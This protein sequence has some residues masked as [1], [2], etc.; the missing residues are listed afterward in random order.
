MRLKKITL[1][2]FK[3][4][5][6]KITL[7]FHPG[8]TAIVGPNGCGKS[9]IAD[10]FRWVLGEQSAK[11]LRGH[12]MQDVIFAGTSQRRPVNLSEVT[13]TLTDIDGKLPVEFDEVAISRRLHRSGESEYLL[14]GSEVRLKDLQAL[15][16]DSGIGKEAFSIFEQGK[17]DQV[18]HY[19]PLERRSIFEEAAGIVRFL[20]RK[21]EALRKLEQTELNL[22]RLVDILN[23]VTQRVAV[24]EE[25]AAKARQF[26]EKKTLFEGLE[27]QLL[28][29]KW[30]LGKQKEQQ[31]RKND[32]EST[33]QVQELMEHIGLLR[34]SLHQ[35]RIATHEREQAWK[36]RSA[37]MYAKRNERDLFLRDKSHLSQKREELQIN[38]SS[39]EQELHTLSRQSAENVNE[40][41]NLQDEYEK[42]NTLLNDLKT[43]LDQLRN[44][45]Q[46]KTALLDESRRQY[47]SSQ[48]KR[49]TATQTHSET[50]T[51]WKQ[52][53]A[54]LTLLEERQPTLIAHEK[55]LL[56]Q[57][58]ETSTKQTNRSHELKQL[59]EEIDLRKGQLETVEESLA[60]TKESLAQQ[61]K[62][63]E[64]ALRESAS[65]KAR[66]D[67]LKELQEAMEGSSSACKR[68]I[69]EAHNPQSLLHQKLTPLY[70]LLT[71]PAGSEQAFA[72]A[73]RT[74]S[75]VLAVPMHQDLLNVLDFAKSRQLQDFALF[76]LEKIPPSLLSKHFL[77]DLNT[78]ETLADALQSKTPAW[79]EEGMYIDA[80]N[81]LFYGQSQEGNPF[82]R[83]A[84]IALL[85]E[86][87][88]GLE[89][90]K[91]QHETACHQLQ[92]H[93]AE[94]QLKRSSI[95]K[96]M[97]TQEMKLVEVNYSLLRHQA[98]AKRLE[99]EY[100]TAKE[101]SF[102]MESAIKELADHCQRLEK[103][104]LSFQQEL[105]KWGTDA[106]EQQANLEELTLNVKQA[107]EQAESAHTRWQAAASQERQQ[108]HTL[109]LHQMKQQERER[110]T[111]K[112]QEE[113]TQAK[114]T[115]ES[116]H[117]TS[118]DTGDQLEVI[119]KQLKK[120]EE[121][122]ATLEKNTAESKALMQSLDEQ[123]QHQEA[124]LKSAETEK[125]KS[126]LQFSQ[127]NTLQ[128]AIAQAFQ[129]K[130]S[131]SLNDFAFS[132][133]E[134]LKDISSVE[135]Q[136]RQLK[137][138][139]DASQDINMLAIEECAQ[140]KQRQ[141]FLE[142]QLKD[143]KLSKQELVQMIAE[144]DGQSRKLFQETFHL[145]RENFKKN[146]SILFNGG[147]ADLH[148]IEGEDLLE[149]GIEIS[150]RPP[151]K[152]MRSISLLSGGEKCLTAMA[153]L[154]AIFEVK[155]SPYCILDEIDAPLDD[156]NVERFLN[157]VKQF[158]DRCQFIIITHNKRT[159]AIADR[160]Y[161]VSMQE[162]G[163][164][165]LLCME[166][167]T[168]EVAIN[169]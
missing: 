154:F 162:K 14:N 148:F 53:Q 125:N 140:D 103:E 156:T 169:H 95:D 161:G 15:F 60:S 126:S 84:E 159:M 58:E 62:Q 2:G 129:E 131:S 50:A 121:S 79:A 81:V 13:V 26:K 38:I 48:R 167:A 165:K 17:I 72:A 3:S 78:V 100:R 31:L 120:W 135:R 5:A 42:T 4:F 136:L 36:E 40:K 28:A 46:Q 114:Q 149:A 9:N 57:K 108:L 96:E 35:A 66:L 76:C 130:F 70:E 85:E 137:Q 25:Q 133:Q 157:V 122:C 151:G 92:Q 168:A 34:N 63:R 88:H 67:A 93:I 134:Y 107:Q 64:S 128:E 164:S 98:D 16:F 102:S 113:I 74:Y 22:S 153:L 111:L 6:D 19:T 27:K 82:L 152:Q 43:T 158:V 163:V 23:E 145:I 110:R 138:E 61:Q 89:K 141:E 118:A 144:L 155:P 44:S 8:I 7:E 65:L 49:I 90:Q 24:L 47:E 117:E 123:I 104:A 115:L 97:R 87:L 109:E 105:E 86:K 69:E 119:Q 37:E 11:S 147:E 18:I 32:A 106:E 10:A 41:M 73:M 21:K 45:F 127:L 33:L 68:L 83:E 55:Q 30:H 77:N 1:F 59:S 29:T 94:L 91:K 99:E 20:F 150:A 56:A 51:K 146:F 54:R 112:L 160:I 101:E 143:L 166:F 80:K 139:L 132:P 39:R 12:K 142:A 75:T 124:L 52:F 116:L 71:P